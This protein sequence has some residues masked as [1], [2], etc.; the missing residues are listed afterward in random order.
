MA[1]A[2]SPLDDLPTSSFRSGGLV[3]LLVSLCCAVAASIAPADAAGL[4]ASQVNAAEFSGRQPSA[5]ETSPLSVRLEVLLARAHFSPGEIDG[6]FGENARKA[7]HA[8]AQAQQLGNGDQLTPEIW[9]KL[10]A[11]DRPVLATYRITAQDLAGPFLKKLP[12]KME[13]MKHLHHLAY[14]SP[15]EE[16]AEKFHMSEALLGALNPGQRFR[17]AGA[18]IIVT[19]PAETDAAGA[20]AAVKAD[21]ITIDKVRQTV[22]VFDASN[23]LIDFFPATVG[24]AE[25]PSPTGTLKVTYIDHNPTYHYNPKYHFKGVRATS[26]FVIRPGPN[27]PVGTVWVSLSAEGYGI[28]GTPDPGTVSKAASH[29]CVRLTNWDAQ[30]LAM[31]VR[32]GTPVTFVDN[33]G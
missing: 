15:R 21:H 28:H 25:K 14:T 9:Q 13:E 2:T 18:T 19:D 6:K 26:P 7:L 3:A 11:D 29:G 27:N 8:Y 24:S 10:V 32:K 1:H 22:E 16:L 31:E 17:K 20:N 4:T 23:R 12:R 30:H 33:S 5:H